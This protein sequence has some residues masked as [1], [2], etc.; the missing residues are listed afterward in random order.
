MFY[1]NLALRRNPLAPAASRH[2]K[3]A[4]KVRDAG[5]HVLRARGA[6]GSKV[7]SLARD[8]RLTL[9]KTLPPEKNTLESQIGCKMK[10]RKNGL[11]PSTIHHAAVWAEKST[12]VERLTSDLHVNEG[13]EIGFVRNGGFLPCARIELMRSKSHQLMS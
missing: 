8:K 9:Q 11:S 1:S 12:G 4:K 5:M 13:R 2:T 7:D 6:A 10:L 3:C